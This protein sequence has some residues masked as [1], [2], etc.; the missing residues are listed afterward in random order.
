[1]RQV[2]RAVAL[3]R[4]RVMGWRG[5]W[6]GE[7]GWGTCVNPW[8][9]HVNVWQKPLQYCKVINLQ[10]KN[11]QT[12]PKKKKKKKTTAEDTSTLILSRDILKLYHGSKDLE[13]LE[14]AI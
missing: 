14:M 11:K 10:L 4:P 3:G 5:K 8:L 9:V 1:M 2:L 6:Q 12:T 7:S 13:V